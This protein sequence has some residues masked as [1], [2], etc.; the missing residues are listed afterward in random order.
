MNNKMIAV[1][2]TRQ[3]HA[4]EGIDIG[5]DRIEFRIGNLILRCKNRLTDVYQVAEK[6][7]LG[8]PRRSV[9]LSGQP[10]TRSVC[11]AATALQFWNDGERENFDNYLA[12]FPQEKWP[13][14][15]KELING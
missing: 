10:S 4:G 7:R 2:I 9:N 1:E 6:Y 3:F 12:L 11:S 8:M 5:N 14:K 13:Q 15:I